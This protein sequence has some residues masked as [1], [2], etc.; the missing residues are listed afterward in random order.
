MS[1]RIY[2]IAV[3]VLAAIPL[4]SQ[5]GS[6]GAQ[7]AGEGAAIWSPME[8]SGDAAAEDD[9]SMILP[10]LLN[11]EGYS[12]TFASETP[13]T[14][15]MSG[16][17]DFLTVY[18]DNILPFSGPGVSDVKYSIE[19]SIDLQQSRSRL[20]WDLAYSPGF[21]FYQRNSSLNGVDHNL[22]LNF[23]YRVSPHVTLSAGETFQ[24]ATDLLYSSDI[25]FAPS[26]TPSLVPPSTPRITNL[27]TVQA[28]YQFSQNG[29]V[30]IKGTF[31]GLWYS[32][33]S[34]L[35]RLFDSTGGGSEV[36]YV[37]RLSRS[38]YLGMTYGFQKLFTH[39]GKA[40][41]QT[42]SALL[43]YTFAL[44]P[45]LEI[46]VF[47]G[48]EHADTHNGNALPLRNWL[49]ATGF[50]LAWHGE[51]AT[52]LAGY[53]KRL[54]DGGGL[55]AAVRSDRAE[56][57]VRWQLSRSLTASLEGSYWTNHLLDSQSE[58]GFGGHTWSET[59][60]LNRDIGE[61][62]EAKIGYTRLYQTYPNIPA[63]ASAPNRN[64]VWV[65]ISYKFDRPLGR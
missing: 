50:N 11:D 2:L 54:S 53:S 64:N 1:G 33:R 8:A 28:T 16:A 24:K 30:G 47:A 9:A 17:L 42:Q 22:A 57:A 32:S 52:V 65:S 56:A 45:T 62:L 4:W 3:L 34:N 10:A 40:E 29:M 59:A 13:R 12:L 44:P 55:A 36:F 15:Y 19:P 25:S 31:S 7:P 26:S 14:N 61:R 39:P 58:F 49:P 20:S 43:F 5:G 48:P 51:R 35:N 60:S 21:R 46:S 38:H 63:I 27:S 6:S 37:H 23:Q 18:D 41:T